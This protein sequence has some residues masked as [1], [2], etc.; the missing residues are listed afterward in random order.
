MGVKTQAPQRVEEIMTRDPLCVSPGTTASE[1][2][3][4]LEANEISGVPVV[5][6]LNRVVGVV[7][8]TDLLHRCLSGPV[9]SGPGT[10]F[11]SL[12]E[13][14]GVG[15]EL[16][17]ESLGSV[18]EFMSAEPVT[19]SPDESISFVARRLADERIHRIVVVDA[20]QHVL[21]IVTSLDLLREFPA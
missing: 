4:L 2:A 8:K 7:S 13:G 16:D 1:L 21:G 12:A 9:G 5:D 3:Q 19:A 6:G 15:S 18:E 11:R 20:E 10:F 17:P 14:I